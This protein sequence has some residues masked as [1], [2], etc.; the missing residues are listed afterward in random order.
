MG[1]YDF[2]P[3]VP[4]GQLVG[5]ANLLLTCKACVWRGTYDLRKV[6]AQLLARDVNGPLIG[7]CAAAAH[8]RIPCPRCGKW[9]WETRPDYINTIPP[10]IPERKK[11]AAP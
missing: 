7:I 8:V 4:L 10:G 6:I 2:Q 3:G 1:R 9:T 5:Q 11:P